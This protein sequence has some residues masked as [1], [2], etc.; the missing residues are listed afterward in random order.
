MISLMCAT[1]C[2]FAVALVY[3]VCRQAYSQDITRIVLYRA[4]H[5]TKCGI[6]RQLGAM[7]NSL[8][9]ETFLINKK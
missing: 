1:F 5:G 3:S 9:T 6:L 7:H 8:P 4:Q 2:I